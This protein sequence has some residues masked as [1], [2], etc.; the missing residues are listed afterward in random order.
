MSTFINSVHVNRILYISLDKS[1]TFLC[2]IKDNIN[3]LHFL[4][5]SLLMFT[6]MNSVHVNR[7]LYFSLVV[8]SAVYMTI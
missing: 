5:Y 6:F 7:F 8:Y 4:K 1:C 3:H 2:C